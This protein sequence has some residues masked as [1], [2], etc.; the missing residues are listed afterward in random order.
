M[1]EVEMGR[2]LHREELP[3]VID[4]HVV[5]I[6]AGL[7]QHCAEQ[8]RFIL[9]VTIA[10]REYLRGGMWHISAYANLNAYVA[11][12]MLHIRRQSADFLQR[13]GDALHQLSRLVSDLRRNV[14]TTGSQSGIPS[15]NLRPCTVAL[16]R[17]SGIF[18][19]KRN[20]QLA[21]D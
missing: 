13:I 6:D 17:R 1:I 3:L 14:A 11:D 8:R 10:V 15:A 19:S 20:P 7:A 2:K 9:A 21:C 5:G 18:R 16:S 12:V 4:Q